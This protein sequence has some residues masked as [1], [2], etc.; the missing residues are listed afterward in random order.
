VSEGRRC[1]ENVQ[2]IFKKCEKRKKRDKK[3]EKRKKRVFI[4]MGW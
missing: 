3:N 4:C 2:K 1:K